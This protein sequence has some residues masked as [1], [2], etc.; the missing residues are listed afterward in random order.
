MLRSQ[1]HASY[2]SNWH[3]AIEGDFYLLTLNA[4]K[5]NLCTRLYRTA[6]NS[7]IILLHSLCHCP[8]VTMTMWM[9]FSLILSLSQ[10]S[11]C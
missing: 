2:F 4:E 6:M 10:F 7:L 1:H 11:P 3:V 5:Y 8:A 9:S